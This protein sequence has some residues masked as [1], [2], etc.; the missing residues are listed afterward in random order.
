MK[1][2]WVSSA[3]AAAILMGSSLVVS[4]SASANSNDLQMR[5]CLLANVSGSH[6][7]VDGNPATQWAC[8]GMR[9]VQTLQQ[10][11]SKGWTVKAMTTVGDT[12]GQSVLMVI[13]H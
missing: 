13:E 8:E 2:F 4:G 11:A 12:A 7:A 1:T 10:L 9:S 3:L 5:S 6:L